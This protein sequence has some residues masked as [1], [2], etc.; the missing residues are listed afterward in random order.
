[1]S[2]GSFIGRDFENVL[3]T[4]PVFVDSSIATNVD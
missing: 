2:I 3:N 4:V 1:M